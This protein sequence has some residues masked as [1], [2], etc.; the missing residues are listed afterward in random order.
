MFPNRSLRR[1][2]F[3]RKLNV[4]VKMRGTSDAEKLALIA[5]R[6]AKEYAY[7]LFAGLGKLTT[8]SGLSSAPRKE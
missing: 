6:E 5:V 8:F 1:D 2:D 3:L 7:D 4:A